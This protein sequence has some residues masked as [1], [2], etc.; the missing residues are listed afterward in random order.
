LN[1]HDKEQP[2]FGSYFPQPARISLRQSM[3]APSGITE[4]DWRRFQAKKA[5]AAEMKA[6]AAQA[7]TFVSSASLNMTALHQ[8]RTSNSAA[9]LDSAAL[10]TDMSRRYNLAPAPRRM[11]PMSSSSTAVRGSQAK[12]TSA[13][14][15]LRREEKQHKRAYMEYQQ[16]QEEQQQR[17]LVHVPPAAPKVAL[18]DRYCGSC[19]ARNRGSD[20]TCAACGYFLAG[21]AN[22]A[23]QADTLAQRRGLAPANAKA[24]PPVSP[25]E[26]AAMESALRKR[27]DAFCPIC[28]EAFKGEE[29]LLSC[30]H[31][32]HRA[33]LQIFEKFMAR[34]VR[35]CPICRTCDYQK[36]LT[37]VG[38][39]AHA[40]VCCKQIQGLYRG[41]VARKV[42]RF[43][44]KSYYK[45]GAGAGSEARKRFFE[46]ELKLLGDSLLKE[47]HARD[48]GLN[49]VVRG[50][51]RT[52]DEGRELDVLFD[53]MLAQRQVAREQNP[54]VFG[55][56]ARSTADEEEG[57]YDYALYGD[58]A[59]A[60]ML[61]QAEQKADSA[62]GT[63]GNTTDSLKAAPLPVLCSD[64]WLYALR[65]AKVR[66]LGECAICMAPNKGMRNVCILSCSHIFHSQCIV[67]F[68]KFVVNT[69]GRGC[70]VCRANFIA[71]S[72]TMG[73]ELVGV[74]EED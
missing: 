39:E 65:R 62:S 25:L 74:G 36:K 15:L 10:Q 68:E 69:K 31:L 8:S 57:R 59:S 24:L 47:T 18:P 72:M 38:S 12:L 52:L 50:I 19:S 2:P 13:V 9:L 42:Y 41:Y 45:K 54:H 30:S 44:L 51:D 66:G 60:D 29:V 7:S 4:H 20:S 61:D 46:R 14:T 6:E 49:D 70:P 55:L 32:F 58:N 22:S 28:M 1:S 17:T 3:S 56:D 53:T 37:R 64:D 40:E 21:T 67:N 33:C 16:Q 63:E 27:N 71:R 73:F 43:E 34:G 48:R 11:Q 35:T 5:R 23:P 26:W